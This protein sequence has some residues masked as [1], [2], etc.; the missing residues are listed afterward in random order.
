MRLN[1]PLPQMISAAHRSEAGVCRHGWN[2][3]RASSLPGWAFPARSVRRFLS[4]EADRLPRESAERLGRLPHTLQRWS[5]RIRPASTPIAP[6][7]P[8]FASIH[9]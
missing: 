9:P 3:Y 5:S 6:T 2:D 4:Y 7:P 1:L 8:S